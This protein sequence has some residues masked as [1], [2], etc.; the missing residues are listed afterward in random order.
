MQLKELRARAVRQFLNTL[1]VK[2]SVFDIAVITS[3]IAN[4]TGDFIVRTV[5]LM[6]LQGNSSVK[7]TT[8]NYTH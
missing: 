5:V 8:K 1:R 2:K 4:T 6:C 7:R 3:V